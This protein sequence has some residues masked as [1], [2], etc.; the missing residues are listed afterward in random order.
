MYYSF[1]VIAMEGEKRGEKQKEEGRR[2][3]CKNE[4][5]GRLRKSE[6]RRLRQEEDRET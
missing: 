6:S 5:R 4:E 1:Y 2:I 3:D